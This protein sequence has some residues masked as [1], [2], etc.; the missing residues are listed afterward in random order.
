MPIGILVNVASVVAGDFLGSLIG[1]KLSEQLKTT[2][3]TAFGVC[4]M[5]MGISSIPM[6]KNMPAVI[7]AVILGTL[8][9]ILLDID[10]H[11]RKGTGLALKKLRLSVGDNEKLMVTAMVLFCASGTGIYGSLTSGMTG[12]HSILIAKSVLDFFTSMIFACQ[13]QKST[14]L[15]GVPQM[16][17][18]LTLFLLAKVIVPMTNDSMISDFKACGGV[19]LLATGLTI[20]KVKD[21]PVVDMIPGMILAMPLSAF[22]MNIIAP[23]F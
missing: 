16:I 10:G 2:M 19:V 3:T 11:I 12:D 21:I 4:A 23:L 13:L 22:W 17:I 5:S 8:I 7:F 15:I 20:M 18:M 9:G 1:D 14:M 6:M